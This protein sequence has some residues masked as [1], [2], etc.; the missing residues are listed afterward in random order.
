MVNY[1]ADLKETIETLRHI[2][3]KLNPAKCTFGL[4]CGKFLG[5]VIWSQGLQANPEKVNI[6]VKMRS[7]KTLRE[8]QALVS[9]L[10]ALDH[11][12]S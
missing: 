12:L 1:A 7:P 4:E 9:R 6:L 2:G 10:V 3:L 11:F 5:H 8:V